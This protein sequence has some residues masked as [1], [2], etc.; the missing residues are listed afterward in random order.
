M[1]TV[2]DPYQNMRAP[3]VYGRV[4]RA[5]ESGL[6]L[7]K[8]CMSRFIMFVLENRI[9]VTALSAF[10]PKFRNSLVECMVRIKPEQ[11]EAFERETGGKLRELPKLN[12][13]SGTK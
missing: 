9:E 2:V 5:C 13:N 11:F 4:W 7:N 8:A 12:L 1:T 6:A 3:D 10:D